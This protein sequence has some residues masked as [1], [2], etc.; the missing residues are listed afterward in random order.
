MSAQ[1]TY[2]AHKTPAP[3]APAS[4]GPPLLAD[5]LEE[6]APGGFG[7]HQLP[8][9]PRPAHCNLVCLA[10]APASSS[11]A[12]SRVGAEYLVASAT[13]T[14]RHQTG[15]ARTG[16]GPGLV[17]AVTVLTFRHE[18]GASAQLLGLIPY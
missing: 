18:L 2:S 1:V 5:R 12:G 8:P 4:N 11:R 17:I 3:R 10:P 15:A 6:T 7:L 13:S 9:S 16:Y 14:R